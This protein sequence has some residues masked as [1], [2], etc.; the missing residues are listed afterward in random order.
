MPR[1]LTVLLG[2]FFDRTRGDGHTTAAATGAQ[3]APDTIIITLNVEDADVIAKK[4]NVRTISIHDLEKLRGEHVAAIV[5]NRVLMAIAT[6]TEL[7][8]TERDNLRADR[9]RLRQGLQSLLRSI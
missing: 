3:Y 5:D 7:I 6:E 8:R 1:P 9:E 2:E 4:F